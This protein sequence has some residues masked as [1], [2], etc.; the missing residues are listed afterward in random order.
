MNKRL[1]E[2]KT[3]HAQRTPGPYM[4]DVNTK[5]QTAELKSIISP[6]YLIMDFYR[7][8]FQ[9]AGPVF[10]DF[11]RNIMFRVEQFAK[12]RAANHPT[13][14]MF[15]DHPDAIGLEKSWEDV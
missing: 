1:D 5:H 13:F 14:D 12:P 8:G 15:I 4:W 6:R 7:W 10:R 11:K 3:R 9:G 2:I